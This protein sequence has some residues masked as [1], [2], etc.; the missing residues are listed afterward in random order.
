MKVWTSYYAK[1]DKLRQLGFRDFIAVSGWIPEF[2]R[3]VMENNPHKRL[4]SF[5]RLVELSPKKEWFFDWKEGKLGN[6]EYI[7]LYYETVLNKLDFEQIKSFLNENS[8][9]LCYE[10]RG[11]FCHRH[12]IS[13]WLNEHGIECA[14]MENV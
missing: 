12:L 1:I 7:R 2:Y 4:I 6:E 10:K 11:D 13:D 5:R 9:L 8:V 3:E 14:E